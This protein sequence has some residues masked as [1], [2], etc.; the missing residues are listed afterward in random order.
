MT[1]RKEKLNMSSEYGSSY[2]PVDAN[3]LQPRDGEPSGPDTGYQVGGAHV[4]W[5]SE[6]DVTGNGWTEL[7]NAPHSP[8]VGKTDTDIQK[9]IT[10]SGNL[11]SFFRQLMELS[12]QQQKEFIDYLY[13][14]YGYADQGGCIGSRLY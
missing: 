7:I 13:E 3:V 8:F 10:N 9:E 2:M 12:D 11:D 6:N 4:N 1:K 14:Q 5:D